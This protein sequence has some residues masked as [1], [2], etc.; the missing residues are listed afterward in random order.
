MNGD[1]DDGLSEPFSDEE[2][3]ILRAAIRATEQPT[4]LDRIATVRLLLRIDQ[5]RAEL[6]RAKAANARTSGEV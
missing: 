2:I 4:W 3:A 1:D 5:L 6:K